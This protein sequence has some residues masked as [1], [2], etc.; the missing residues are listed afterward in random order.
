MEA[1]KSLTGQALD[2]AIKELEDPKS[3]VRAFLDFRDALQEHFGMDWRGWERP[4]RDP[5]DYWLLLRTED[6]KIGVEVTM[7]RACEGLFAANARVQKVNDYLASKVTCVDTPPAELLFEPHSA[8][9]L[10]SIP[11]DSACFDPLWAYLRQGALAPSHTVECKF[12]KVQVKRLPTGMGKGIRMVD[13]AFFMMPD[14][15]SWQTDVNEAISIKVEKYKKRPCQ[16]F[17]LLL[18]LKPYLPGTNEAKA[19]LASNVSVRYPN[20]VSVVFDRVY[21][22][23]D[24]IPN[25]DPGGTRVCPVLRLL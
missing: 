22:L 19:F 25:P 7:L 21:A 1:H 20:Q 6:E 10:P 4:P 14:Q 24:Y 11:R 12:G 13:Q 2:K 18:N 9:C 5:P 3:E 8:N 23:T 15:N 17:W 16:P